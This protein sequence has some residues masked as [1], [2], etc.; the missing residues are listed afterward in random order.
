[1]D[2]A[3]NVITVTKTGLADSAT[4]AGIG[5]TS[6]ANYVVDTL[7]P[8][9][10]IGAPSVSLTSAGPV[11]FTVTYTG[12]NIITLAAADVTINPTGTATGT[13]A[14]TGSGSVTRTVTI[15]GVS[16]NGTLGIS[17]PAGT[18]TEIGR[19]SCRERV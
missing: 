7:R 4:N 13:A 14:V 8:S 18:A 16:G 6:S 9:A 1:M 17:L 5:A 2:D 10:S 11:T 12:A 15:S 3:T 19:A